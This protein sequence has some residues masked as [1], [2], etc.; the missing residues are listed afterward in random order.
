[1][2]SLNNKFKR[3]IKD[4]E[5]DNLESAH[6]VEDFIEEVL[7]L[8]DVDS[9]TDDQLTTIY[10]SFSEQQPSNVAAELILS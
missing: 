10:N 7:F 8:S 5:L 1:M 2:S 6:P 3:S 9:L 4:F